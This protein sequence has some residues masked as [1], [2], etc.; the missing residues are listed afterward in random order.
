MNRSTLMTEA[1]QMARGE[2]AVWSRQGHAD[3]WAAADK[4]ERRAMFRFALRRAWTLAIVRKRN[5]AMKAVPPLPVAAPK[6]S[7]SA[8]RIW[9]IESSA[10]FLTAANR[11][12]INRLMA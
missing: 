7:P 6:L 10:D 9:E 2:H 11:D 1:W 4:T 5:A 8:A 3:R 12:E